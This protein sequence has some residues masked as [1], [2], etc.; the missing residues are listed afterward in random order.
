[1]RALQGGVAED[2]RGKSDDF[3]AARLATPSRIEVHANLLQEANTPI[4]D[5][6]QASDI[7]QSPISGPNFPQVPGDSR[8]KSG[9]STRAPMGKVVLEECIDI[10]L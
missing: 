10:R 9:K 8:P 1:V 7:G 2:R 4:K 3:G 6:Q 5:S